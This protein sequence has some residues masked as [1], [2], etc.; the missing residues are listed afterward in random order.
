M[1]AYKPNSNKYKNEQKEERRKV[2]PVVSTPA[3]VKKKSELS[4]FANT[5]ISE[6]A[7]NVKSYIFTDVLVPAIK[8]LVGDI[9]KDGI[10]M[11]LWGGTSRGNSSGGSRASHVSYD[12]FSSGN[13]RPVASSAR[14]PYSYDD[15]TFANRG[16][17]EEVLARMDELVA[18]YGFVTVADLYDLAGRTGNYTDNKYGWT[19]LRN[20]R[21]VRLR[22]GEYMIE[23]PRAYPIDR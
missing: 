15:L 2:E 23:L 19:N 16:E 22:N 9:V 11:I 18:D 7:R 12:R 3:N 10:E 6:D 4:K 17:T 5:F 14:T 20:A 21:I 1:D 13:S 8:K